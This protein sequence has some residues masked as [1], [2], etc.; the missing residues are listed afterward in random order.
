MASNICD[1][2]GGGVPNRP[3]RRRPETAPV[4]RSASSVPLAGS[5]VKIVRQWVPLAGAALCGRR[6]D[7][8]EDEKAVA[9]SRCRTVLLSLLLRAKST[10]RRGLVPCARRYPFGI[11]LGAPRRW[12]HGRGRTPVQQCRRRLIQCRATLVGPMR[13]STRPPR[14]PPPCPCWA[15]PTKVLPG[16]GLVETGLAVQ[17]AGVAAQPFVLIDQHQSPAFPGTLPSAGR[18]ICANTGMAMSPRGRR[19]ARSCGEDH[20]SIPGL[21]IPEGLP[22]TVACAP[23]AAAFAF[24]FGHRRLAGLQYWSPTCLRASLPETSRR[25]SNSWRTV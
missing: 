12:P 20:M 13:T 8:A 24:F 2:A 10:A 11:D 19:T 1:G 18:V 4:S 9:A 14:R 6:D 25:A 21:S 22:A 17:H 15:A 23:S 5:L 7:R 3:D 16:P